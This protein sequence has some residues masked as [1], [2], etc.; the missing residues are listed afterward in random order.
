MDSHVIR[1][2]K[3]REN[4]FVRGEGAILQDS[5]GKRWIDMIGGIAVSALGHA[6][7]ALVEALTDQIGQVLHTCNLYRHPHTEAVAGLL[8]KH[9]GLEATFFSNS[10][11]EA[12][13]CALKAARAY[14]HRGDEPQRRAFVALE[15]GFH[16]RTLG[17][18]SVTWTER[19]R[20]PFEP[21]IPDCHFVPAGDLEAVEA[22]LS[23]LRPAALILEPVQGESGL[24]ALSDEY[25]RGTRELCTATGTVLI[26]D[27]V[28]TGCGRTGTFLA[29]QTAGVIPDIVTLAKPLGAGLPV[30]ATVVAEHLA[31]ALVPGDHGSTFG[32]G[33]LALRAAQTFLELWDAGELPA[34]VAERGAQLAGGLDA[35]VARFDHVLERRGRGLMQGLR[36]STPAAE[37]SALLHERGVLTC[38]AGDNVVRFLPPYVITPAELSLALETIEA[39]TIATQ[40]CRT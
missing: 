2:Y 21:L 12:N 24:R 9:T 22:A 17:A 3:R 20:T 4:V 16:G 5:G 32:G 7:P 30:G 14:H 38:T 6:H 35:L 25:L 37:F 13:E 15:G 10:G 23:E 29:A 1:T 39:C 27:E 8:A 36:L 31:Q 40:P 34:A 26:H 19:Y 28:Q 11:A 18:L 33:P